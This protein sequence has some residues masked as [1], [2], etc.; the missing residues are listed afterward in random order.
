MLCRWQP[1]IDLRRESAP[2]LVSWVGKCDDVPDSEERSAD[3]ALSQRAIAGERTLRIVSASFAGTAL[4]QV[5]FIRRF[6]GAVLKAGSL[7]SATTY[8]SQWVRL[9]GYLFGSDSV[10]SLRRFRRGWWRRL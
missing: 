10:H 4:D 6:G 1:A 8:I 9:G 7:V 3:L 5:F 2:R